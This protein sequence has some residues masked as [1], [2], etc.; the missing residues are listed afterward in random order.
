M[1]CN[2]HERVHILT[3]S[4]LFHVFV[5]VKFFKCS[6]EITKRLLL[7]FFSAT[8][9]LFGEIAGL[10]GNFPAELVFPIIGE[11]TEAA[12]QVGNVCTGVWMHVSESVAVRVCVSVCFSLLLTLCVLLLSAA[13]KDSGCQEGEARSWSKLCLILLVTF[14]HFLPISNQ[15]STF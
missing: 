3:E 12:I 15:I 9:W 2:I 10:E 4:G 11:P 1:T 14:S 7:I 13:S 5:G 6:T 8:G